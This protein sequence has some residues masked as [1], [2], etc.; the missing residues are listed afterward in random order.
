V[1]NI[2][3]WGYVALAGLAWGTYVPIIFYGGT[4]LGGTPGARL[5]GILC[6][7][8]AY[9][10]LGVLFPLV[11]FTTGQQPWPEL[12]TNGLVFSGL[13]GVAGAVGA[14]CVVFA[15]S[16]AVQTA[17]AEPAFKEL[18]DREEILKKGTTADTPERDAELADVRSEMSTYAAKYRLFIA[19]LIFGLAPVINTLL[20]SVWHP[21]PGSPW[22][23]E[24][25]PP[26]W[27]LVAG[28]ILVGAGAFLVLYS[29]GESEVKKK[30][31]PAPKPA[32]AVADPGRPGA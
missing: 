6:V 16:T 11:M 17:K 10:V 27:K 3:W 18:A 5:M 12:K 31:G 30:A 32:V 25:E 20:A 9:F 4:V 15:S 21:K 19:P 23:F 26:G 22:H 7:G 28:I 2:P 24:F 13:A 1:S 8:V 29:H 14:I